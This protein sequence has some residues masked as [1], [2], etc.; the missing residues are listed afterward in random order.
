[1]T[2]LSIE[3]RPVGE[4]VTD[5]IRR[6]I[7]S[8]ELPPGSRLVGKHLA[9]ELG[10]SRTPVREAL[11]RLAQENLVVRRDSGGFE[12]RP[13]SA[14]EVE[15]VVGVRAALESYAME[16]AA[17]RLS[18]QVLQALQRN[19][20]EYAQALKQKK[21][22][23]LVKLNTA[24]HE[25]VYEAA[26]SRVLRGQINEL[27]EILHRFRVAL[28]SEPQAAARSLKDH[29]RLLAALEKGDARLAGRICRE[30]VLAGGEW[31]VSR[32]QDQQEED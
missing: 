11:H 7:L 24:F 10:I 9:E 26:G 19:V 12:V 2:G 3:R 13:L 1:M 8:G 23:R 14:R 21:V 29:R 6:L 16:L 22:M 17:Q 4:Q 18:P 25:T 32:L 5:H 20:E 15:E 31:I 28:L 30:H 27:A